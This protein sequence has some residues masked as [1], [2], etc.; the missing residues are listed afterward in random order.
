MDKKKNIFLNRFTKRINHPCKLIILIS[1][2]L[3]L[4][5]CLSAGQ[6]QF[7]SK[8]HGY[9]LTIPSGWVKVPDEEL[10]Q[11]INELVSGGVKQRMLKNW[12]TAFQLRSSYWLD[13]PYLV[14]EVVEYS[15]EGFIDKPDESDFE[16]L[17]EQIAG[18]DF[19]D[20][21]IEE[22]SSK[23]VKGKFIGSKYVKAFID[24]SNHSYMFEIENTK[25]NTN[26]TKIKIMGF[27]GKNALVQLTFCDWERGWDLTKRDRE[28]LFESFKFDSAMKYDITGF[29][30]GKVT[31]IFPMTALTLL[32]AFVSI[33]YIILLKSWARG[34]E[35]HI[36]QNKTK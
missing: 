36:Q 14:I 25:S 11:A 2:F 10:H 20:F 24:K 35:H 4:G 27:F 15:E 7:H 3:A 29:R 26:N 9:S 31:E 22:H 34:I 5:N 23:D 12:E 28:L 1:I 32:I 17:A 21:D 13:F 19:E 18:F 33:V 8:E 30:E 6:K 16:Y